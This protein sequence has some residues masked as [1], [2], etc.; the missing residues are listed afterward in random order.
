M[1][2]GQLA[3]H[4][5]CDVV[6][7]HHNRRHSLKDLHLTSQLASTVGYDF[8]ALACYSCGVNGKLI[9]G[10]LVGLGIGVK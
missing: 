6:T 2:Q 1:P 8:L 9:R 7:L 4:N 3:D 10:S 5:E